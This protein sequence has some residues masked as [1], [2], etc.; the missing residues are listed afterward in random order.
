M[1]NKERTSKQYVKERLMSGNRSRNR[2]QRGER[3]L[4]S[5]LS[6]ELGLNLNRNL[7]QTRGGG[8]DCVDIPG[9]S[10]ECKYQET[11]NLNSWWQQTLDQAGADE[12]ILF[13]R[14]SRQPFKAMVLLSLINWDFNGT[15][16][17]A[18]VDFQTACMLIRETM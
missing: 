6:E 2:G 8:A 11:L 18:I 10:I 1:G 17:T 3:E 16:Y 4:M 7:S 12:P 13:Y 15:K 5:M 14:Q 9:F